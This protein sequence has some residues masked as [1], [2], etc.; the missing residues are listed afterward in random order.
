MADDQAVGPPTHTV[1]YAGHR[2]QVAQEQAARIVQALADAHRGTSTMMGI[3]AA[4]TG[5]GHTIV[6]YISIGPGIP[7]LVEG[8][9]LPTRS[10]G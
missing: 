6:R 7:V 4:D 10:G 5:N 3:P 2:F 1:Y 9:V 8:P